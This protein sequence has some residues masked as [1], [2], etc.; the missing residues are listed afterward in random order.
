MRV[1]DSA[2]ASEEGDH[3]TSAKKDETFGDV[4]W[5]P[6]TVTNKRAGG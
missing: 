4:S 1:H 6:F 5:V 3:T 2:L